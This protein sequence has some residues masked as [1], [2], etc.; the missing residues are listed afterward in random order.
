M[1]ISFSS[2]LFGLSGSLILGFLDLQAGQAQNRFYNELEDRLS[3]TAA[4]LTPH[5][6]P[7]TSFPP[8]IRKL[9]ERLEADATAPRTNAAMGL[10]AEGV[11]GLVQ[12]MRSEQQMIRDWVEAQASVQNE[13]KALLEKLNSTL[14]KP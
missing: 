14:E 9:L 6:P 1:G 4:D 2:S 10:L 13:V 5:V 8:E 3:A 12:H 11:Q 7:A